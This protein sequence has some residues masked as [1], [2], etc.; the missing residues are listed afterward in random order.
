VTEPAVPRDLPPAGWYPDPAGAAALRWWNGLTWS[1]A[2]HPLPDYVAPSVPRAPGPPLV[3]RQSDLAWSPVVP[4]PFTTPAPDVAETARSSSRPKPWVLVTAVVAGLALLVT[5]L[6]L[7][8]AVIGSRNLLDTAAIERQIA[9]DLTAQTRSNV[10]VS[11][12]DSIPLA[13][14]STF[15]CTATSSDGSS[16]SVLVVQNDDQ[17]NVSW[18]ITR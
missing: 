14:G 5:A 3:P 12:P 2:T 4:D 15:T 16:T 10:T 13:T 11:C 18:S 17:G 7:L 6:A 9:H 1:D 8:P